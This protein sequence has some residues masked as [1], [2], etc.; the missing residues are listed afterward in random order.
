[1]YRLAIL[2]V[3]LCIL[4]IQQQV[5]GVEPSSFDAIEEDPDRSQSSLLSSLRRSWYEQLNDIND[6]EQHDDLEHLW[7]RFVS[8]LSSFRQR[9]RFGNTRY[10]RSLPSK[11][12]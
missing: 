10:G 7:K 3:F 6:N 2:F 8:E 9:R 12:K 1:M 5:A 4:F 11:W